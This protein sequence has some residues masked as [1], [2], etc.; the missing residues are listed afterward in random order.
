FVLHSDRDLEMEEV[1]RC[2]FQ[3]APQNRRLTLDYLKLFTQLL[4][5]QHRPEN[6]LASAIGLPPNLQEQDRIF[7]WESER[8]ALIN[9]NDGSRNVSFKVETFQ[10]LLQGIENGLTELIHHEELGTEETNELKDVGTQI[11]Q[12]NEKTREWVE[13]VLHAAGNRCGQEFGKYLAE[14]GSDE[15]DLN[16]QAKIQRWCDFDSDVGFGRFEL[17]PNTIEIKGPRLIRCDI[18]L[19]ESF[20]TP[21]VDTSF[22]RP[23]DHRFCAFMVGY[24]EGVLAQILENPVDIDHRACD[25]D[26]VEHVTGD[27]QSR[28]ESCRFH[29]AV[30]EARTGSRNHEMAALR[31]AH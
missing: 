8:G 22:K 10:L 6:G 13:N 16:V 30:R 7:T 24:I 14:S 23:G 3:L 2:G 20:L 19:R 28:S 25:F 4:E 26:A 31:N 15:R 11:A 29:V 27:S 1:I 21:A 17:D 18:R 5:K 9:P 12:A